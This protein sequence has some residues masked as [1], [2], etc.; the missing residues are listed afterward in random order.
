MRRVSLY[1]CGVIYFTHR[2]AQRSVSRVQNS[3]ELQQIHGPKWGASSSDRSEIIRRLKI[4]PSRS[5]PAKST[6]FIQINDPVLAPMPAAVHDFD[7]VADERMEG[8]CDMN[9]LPCR[10]SDTT[11]I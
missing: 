7:R 11:S 10:L 3:P 5:D 9:S 6:R 4:G 1:V 8:V 2:Y